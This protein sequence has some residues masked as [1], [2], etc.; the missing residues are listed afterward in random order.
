MIKQILKFSFASLFALLL[1]S[2]ATH[3]ASAATCSFTGASSNSWTN[4]ANWSCGII[5]T[6]SDDVIINSTST[7]LTSTTTVINSLVTNGTGFLNVSN[8]FLTINTSSTNN[9]S[10]LINGAS[11]SVI[12]VY[13]TTTNNGTIQ[14]DGSGNSLQANL[15]G[16]VINNGTS[17]I[18]NGSTFYL[19]GLT[20]AGNLFT[21][22]TAALVMRKSSNPTTDL[23]GN[24]NVS[25]FELENSSLGG[26]TLNLQG[27]VT[28]TVNARLGTDSTS[29][30]TIAG[31]GNTIDVLGNASFLYSNATMTSLTVNYTGTGTQTL[32][33]GYGSLPTSTVNKV[34]GSLEVATSTTFGQSFTISSGTVN[35]NSSSLEINGNFNNSGTL[36][37][38]AASLTNIYGTTTNSGTINHTNSSTIFFRGDFVNSGTLNSGPSSVGFYRDWTGASGAVMTSGTYNFYGSV[39]QHIPTSTAFYYLL[40]NKSGG[41][42]FM[43]GNSSVIDVT[44]QSGN[45]DVRSGQ[46]LTVTGNWTNT[47]GTLIRGNTR[48]FLFSGSAVQTITSEPNF[49]LLYINKSGGN[50]QLNGNLGT[51]AL[52]LSG[53]GPLN[54]WGNTIT[55]DGGGTGGSRA[56]SVSSP[57]LFNAGT[58]TFNY[59]NTDFVTDIEPLNYY[60]LNLVGNQLRHINASTTASNSFSNS[61]TLRVSSTLNAPGAYTN[62]GYVQLNG[63]SIIHPATINFSNNSGVTVTS[64]TIGDL[65]YI[66]LNDGNRNISATSVESVTSTITGP[67]GDS[68]AIT[69]TETGAGTGIFRNTTGIFTRSAST[70]STNDG[71]LTQVGG[72][73]ATGSYT[74]NQDGTDARTANTSLIAASSGSSGGGGGGGGGAATS[75]SGLAPLV[76]QFQTSTNAAPSLLS[77]TSTVEGI[78]MHSIVKLPD[79]KNPNT[80]SDTA[81]YYIGLDGKRHA[82]PNSKVY[83]SWFADF[84]QV[85]IVSADQLARIPLGMNVTYR[86]GSRMV[87][88]TTD[89]KV[90]LVTKGGNLRWVKTEQVAISLYGSSWNTMIDDISDAFYANYQFGLEINSA[91]DV[92]LPTIINSVTNISTNMF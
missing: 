15:Y 23:I 67:A 16:Y 89:P 32:T 91:S 49:Q 83:F 85:Q 53:S 55:V 19:N 48:S 29:V 33:A 59:T 18:S 76:T 3:D 42:L 21:S 61:G 43:D 69:L 84:S 10:I 35:M 60:K 45:F 39:D 11:P 1:A 8:S 79:D 22:S 47:G 20:N 57:A 62:S 14:T 78:A 87:K 12:V 9:G 63:G 65:L 51:L 40:I 72:V 66:T 75:G 77:N 68:E 44:F 70:F 2:M 38:T 92:S 74:D 41:T 6:E 7:V 25:R 4:A 64:T 88:F 26:M 30:L 24:I 71:E 54:A 86:P 13:A 17:Y 52:I 81:V 80:Q 73:S 31:N 37:Y 82:F 34:S 27:H 56:V 5:P 58:S 50:V 36:N 46:T 28:S 90:Y